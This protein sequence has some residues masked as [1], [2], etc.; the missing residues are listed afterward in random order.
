M[1]PA[2]AVLHWLAEGP[3]PEE[4][5]EGASAP[6]GGAT[7]LRVERV[8]RGTARVLVLGQP[9]DVTGVASV[10]FSLTQLPGVERVRVCCLFRHDGTR[11]FV[12]TRASFRGWQGEPCAVRRENRCRRDG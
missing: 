9:L 1:P 7:G 11:I 5:A 8:E 3:T 2:D 4:R 6:I 10:V 12:H